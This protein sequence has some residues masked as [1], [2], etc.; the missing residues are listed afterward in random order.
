[1]NPFGF[2]F[3]LACPICGNILKRRETKV[4][5]SC[6]SEL[7]RARVTEP[8]CGRCGK[9]LERLE[10]EYCYDCEKK[11]HQKSD[12]LCQGTALWVYNSIMKKAMA[13][14]KYEGCYENASF[15]ADEFTRF[16]MAKVR[17]WNPDCLIPVPLHRHRRWFRGYN[18]AQVLAEE[19]GKRLRLPV[20]TDILYRRR[21]TDPQKKLDD[22]AR[23]RN[24]SSAFYVRESSENKLFGKRVVL[25]DDIYTTGSTLEACASELKKAGVSQVY[26]AC[27]CIGR[28]Y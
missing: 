26:F 12:S 25:I 13:L 16:R 14:F 17:S 15:F 21:D 8:V 9:P 19:I 28:D 24:M 7:S 18:Q 6:R 2:L 20:E 23:R 27:L 10:I 3:P 1:M 11:R 22:K 4:C 5:V